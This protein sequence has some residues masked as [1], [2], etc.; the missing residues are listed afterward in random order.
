M[1]E[2][3]RRVN[4]VREKQPLGRRA[5]ARPRQVA[6]L[7]DRAEPVGRVTSAPHVDQRAY[8]RPHHIPQKPVRTDRETHRAA[9]VDRP[10]GLLHTADVGLVVRIELGERGEVVVRGQHRR[11]L[12]HPPDVERHVILPRLVP[13]E[14]ILARLDEV[15]VLPFAGVE[16]GVCILR[17]GRHAAHGNVARQ[18]EIELVDRLRRIGDGTF[19]IEVRHV[20]GRIDPRVGT[21]GARQ[22]N[23][24]AQQ[25]SE[26]PFERLLHRRL[27]GLP[28]P[29]AVGSPVVPE[30]EKIAHTGNDLSGKYTKFRN[31]I[32]RSPAFRFI[33]NSYL[34]TNI[35]TKQMK[36]AIIGYGKMGRE[37]ERILTER[38]HEAALIIDTDNAHELDAAHLA[39]I[40]VALEFTTPETAYRNIRTC[41]ECGVAAVSGTTGWTDRLG[42]LQELCRERGGALFYAS[43]YCLGVN[44][45]FRLNR[46]LAAMI[47]RVGGYDVRIEEVHHTQKKDAPSGT[48]IT[49]AE[50]IVENLAGKQGWVNLAPGI[51]HAANRIERSG[52]APADRIE[53]RSVR[54][55]AV[56]GI[57]TVTYESEDDVLEIRHTIKNRRTLALGAVV[58]AEFLCGKQGVYSMDDLL[59][60][61]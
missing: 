34:C 35:S 42:E 23:R 47:D 50:G 49:L 5:G 7:D 14:G 13:R 57:H 21:P 46:Q 16:A 3:V 9:G 25:G 48:A 27:V 15:A 29:A 10:D 61:A 54:E 43:N 53:I 20:V 44:L 32:V 12:V 2:Y 28:L 52:E 60:N 30:F 1:F 37:I 55:G 59:R 45:M 58:A 19:A 24:F 11:R 8:Q 26:R 40:D 22:S 17:H 36:A 18:Q 6:A 39:G 4:H 38:G 56:P 41:I 51:E 33:N 31:T